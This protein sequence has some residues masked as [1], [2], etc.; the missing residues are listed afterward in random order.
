LLKTRAAPVTLLIMS[1]TFS[2]SD[3]ALHNKPDNLW[4]VIDEGVY[5]LTKFQDEH[6]GEFGPTVFRAWLTWLELPFRWK[7][8]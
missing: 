8:E 5:D 3:V 7:E 4:V 1:Q 2:K 6:P